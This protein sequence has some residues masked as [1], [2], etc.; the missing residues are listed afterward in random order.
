MPTFGMMIRAARLGYRWQKPMGAFV[1]MSTPSP[2]VLAVQLH[3]LAL[4]EC[5]RGR[6]AP[7]YHLI[8]WEKPN[9]LGILMAEHPELGLARIR[10]VRRPIYFE[11][12]VYE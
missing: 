12:S 10:R 2:G 1:R 11:V 4:I 5:S 8:W 7:S 9:L 3:P 6:Q